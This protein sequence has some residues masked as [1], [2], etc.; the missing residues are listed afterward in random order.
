MFEGQ[1]SFILFYFA[2][3]FCSVDLTVLRAYSVMEKRNFSDY[4]IKIVDIT[5]LSFFK[6][7]LPVK[8]SLC[9]RFKSI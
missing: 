1:H 8:Y 2:P 4:I 3:S 7:P 5:S 9:C 6:V